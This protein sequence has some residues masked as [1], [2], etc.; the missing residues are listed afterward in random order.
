MKYK[1]INIGRDK[2]N[3]EIE[4]KSESQLLKEVKKNLMSRHIELITDDNGESFRVY[5]GVR[6]VGTVERVEL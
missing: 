5:A 1:L 3:R 6:R 2:I 4:I